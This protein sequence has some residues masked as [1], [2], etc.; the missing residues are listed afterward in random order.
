[1]GDHSI[2]KVGRENSRRG[3][4]KFYVETLSASLVDSWTT[5]VQ[6]RSQVAQLRQNRRKHNTNKLNLYFRVEV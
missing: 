4:F 3:S 5:H 1:M 6:G 2:W